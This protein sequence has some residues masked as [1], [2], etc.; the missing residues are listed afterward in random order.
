MKTLVKTLNLLFFLFP[1]AYISIDNMTG[2]MKNTSVV[3]AIIGYVYKN[4]L[5]K[6]CMTA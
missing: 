1:L 5:E 4:S 6:Y 3:W 2:D